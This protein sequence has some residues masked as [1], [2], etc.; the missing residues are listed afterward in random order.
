M[1][2][3]LKDLK[4]SQEDGL[5]DT[6]R[7]IEVITKNVLPEKMDEQGIQNVKIDG[8][9]RVSLRGEVYASILAENRD[10][11]YAWLRETGR[12]SLITNTV[13]PSTL[14]AAAREWLK[15][16]EEIPEFIKITP[17]TVATLTRN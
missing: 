2:R 8:V 7:V 5:K 12:A 16:G 4:E 6:N 3:E 1:L 17:V 14:K 10:R 13:N 9:G 15:N 11:A